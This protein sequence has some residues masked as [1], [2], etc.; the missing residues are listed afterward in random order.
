MLV[1]SSADAPATVPPIMAGEVFIFTDG[2]IQG[3]PGGVGGY[4]AVLLAPQA[5]GRAHVLEIAGG[6]RDTTNNRMEMQGAL[7]ALLVLK[8]PTQ[9]TIYSDS[10]YVV[11]GMSE[12][13]HG[14]LRHNPTL[15]DVKNSDLWLRLLQV[16]RIHQVTWQ[17]VRG[18][19]GYYWNERADVLAGH[20][21]RQLRQKQED[22][23]WVMVGKRY[24][25]K[26]R[27]TP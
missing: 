9:A 4:G 2:S 12:W 18:H 1:L 20:A 23:T 19:S 10:Q 5:D 22:P 14:W 3:N 11:K 17:W 27:C 25:T 15:K 7:T 26:R 16:S 21:V 13:I 8:K 6:Y 24:V